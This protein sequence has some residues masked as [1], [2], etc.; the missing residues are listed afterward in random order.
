MAAII[1][2]NSVNCQLQNSLNTFIAATKKAKSARIVNTERIHGHE[3]VESSMYIEGITYYKYKYRTNLYS[4]L[5]L[6]I[7]TQHSIDGGELRR[8]N[9]EPRRIASWLLFIGPV[10]DLNTRGGAQRAI[11]GK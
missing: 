10:L 3:G 2:W 5:M 1:Q 11:K 4:P 9:S 6:S 8:N 7:L